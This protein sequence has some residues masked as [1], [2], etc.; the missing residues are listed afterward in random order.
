MFFKKR[1]SLGVDI[2][3]YSIE[4]ISLEE[5]KTY[6][7]LLAMS[8]TVLD[9]AI[10]S[11]GEVINKE[12]LKNAL[13]EIVK[14]PKF[15]KIETNYAVFSLPESESF[16]LTVSLPEEI[17]EREIPEYVRSQAI[18][19]FP[20]PIEEL[21]F[22]YRVLDEEIFMAAATRDTINSYLEVINGA[23]LKVL[24]IETESMSLGR[25]LL[26]EKGPLMILD[27][28]AKV[29]NFIICDE[30]RLKKSF[31]LP[32]A[33]ENFTKAIS[34]KLDISFD[35]AETLKRKAG[36]NPIPEEG[37]VFL[38]LQKEISGIV[39]EIKKL[40]E[41][42]YDKTGKKI[43]KII[44]V[45]GS[46]SLLHL[47]EYL[48]ENLLKLVEIGDPWDIMNIDILNKEEYIDEAYKTNPIIYATSLGSALRGLDS[49]LE[50]TEINLLPR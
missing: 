10:F 24:A 28:G 3:D 45:G 47:A 12:E 22:D 13:K 14:N 11:G 48:A 36:L 35:E 50:K 4:L 17:K 25:A 40:E 27:I 38:I 2:S 33:G 5:P 29:S 32:I 34:E 23:G 46:A 44:L 8:G 16:I 26:K 43:E 19:S 30:G 7:R 20:Y 39:E 37:R 41:Y 1:K 15:G 42:F 21:Y 31:S 6:P 18:Q 9:P 49:E